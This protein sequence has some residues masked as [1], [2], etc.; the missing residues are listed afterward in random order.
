[1]RSFSTYLEN[2]NRTFTVDV[3]VTLSI[4]AHNEGEAGY[5]AESIIGGIEEQSD[6][7]ILNIGEA[8]EIMNESH[9]H[10][11][12]E[13]KGRLTRTYDL[14][15]FNKSSDFMK[16]IAEL[17]DSLDHH[18]MVNINF[19]KV[20]VAIK[21]NKEDKITDLDH[22]FASELDKKYEENYAN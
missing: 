10:T 15:D 11:W 3:N 22:K 5:M 1:M 6:Y 14:G 2:M 9:G 21:T 7:T 17:A 12:I 4:T 20:T 8:G 13:S 19:G 18:P 16:I